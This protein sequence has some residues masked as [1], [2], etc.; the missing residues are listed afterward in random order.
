MKSMIGDYLTKLG[1]HHKN[2]DP[3]SED[4]ELCKVAQA[5]VLSDNQDLILAVIPASHTLNFNQLQT[6]LRREFFLADQEQT[7][8]LIEQAGLD[9]LVPLGDL[10]NIETLVDNSFVKS[11]R[12][13]FQVAEDEWWSVDG[14][15]FQLLQADAWHIDMCEPILDNPSSVFTLS[16]IKAFSALNNIYLM[17]GGKQL[18]LISDLAERIHATDS[19]PCLPETAHRL[20]QLS[21]ANECDID[22]LIDTIA[23]DPSIAAQVIRY[24][25]ASFFSY[26]GKVNTLRD[27]I[28]RVLGFDAT[29]NIALGIASAE[30]LKM[31][32][33]GKLGCRMFWR[34]AI[35][36]ATLCQALAS[37]MPVKIRPR[38]GMAYLVGLLHNFGLLLMGHIFTE[39]FTILNRAVTE[40]PE[41]DIEQLERDL[42]GI[43]HA[44]IGAWLMEYWDMP[45]DVQT[46]LREMSNGTTLADMSQYTLVLQLATDLLDHNEGSLINDDT[47]LDGSLKMMGI[48]MEQAQ[49]VF[50]KIQDDAYGLEEMAT[51]LA[52]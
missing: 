42:Y 5:F 14:L 29:L 48:S 50:R 37:I 9:C 25:R 38:P 13:V 6:H 24:A 36:M 10:Y 27:A 19:I 15:S 44:E 17:S 35:F 40:S 47:S 31:P 51:R 1:I 26:K 21:Q 22:E 4:I 8:A 46:S 3:V 43:T 16:D 49:A 33:H 41:L 11:D 18:G 23:I 30:V 7:R 12:I 32:R 34:K 39:E 28:T 2:V 52:A 20:L 45:D